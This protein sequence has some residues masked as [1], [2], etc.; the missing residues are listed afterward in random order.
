M[1]CFALYRRL[2]YKNELPKIKQE[3]MKNVELYGI[4]RL[5]WD[6]DDSDTQKL[7]K[8]YYLDNLKELFY[9]QDYEAVFERLY[10]IMPKDE[11]LSILKQDNMSDDDT[12]VKYF[13][14]HGEQYSDMY[15]GLYEEGSPDGKLLFNLV[16]QEMTQ[17][18]HTMTCF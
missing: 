14:M 5:F 2:W 9:K 7:Y 4:Q 6:A 16:P 18:I 11:L 10:N 3:F 13:Q 8:R 17:M 1:Q 15:R 12:L